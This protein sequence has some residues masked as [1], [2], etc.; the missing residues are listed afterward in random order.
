[1]GF[2]PKLAGDEVKLVRACATSSI[3]ISFFHLPD[4]IQ[5]YEDLIKLTCDEY[6]DTR[7]IANFHLGKISIL[8]TSEAETEEEYG[9]ELKML[10]SFLE[11]HLKN[12][13][14]T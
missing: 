5:A 6:A 1:M 11:S 14:S 2:S 13:L 4:Q 9:E 12:H 3:G 7:V 10:L 8:K